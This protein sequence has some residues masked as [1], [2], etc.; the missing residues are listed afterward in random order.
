MLLNLL[1]SVLHSWDLFVEQIGVP[2]TKVSEICT[3]NIFTPALIG[4][5]HALS[6]RWESWVAN[7]HPTYEAIIAVL[8]PKPGQ[9]NPVMNRGLVCD[10]KEF[11]AK[12]QGEF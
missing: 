11:I 8:D 7:C 10:V 1:S 4:F 6:M 12:E 9:T 2:S 3:A 5:S